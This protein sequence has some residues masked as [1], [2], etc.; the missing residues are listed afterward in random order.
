MASTRRPSALPLAGLL[1]LI[2]LVSAGQLFDRVFIIV[3][4]NQVRA[5]LPPC[6]R[7]PPC[8]GPSRNC[9]SISNYS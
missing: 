4:E 8:L 6:P 7:P 3:F 5:P 2:T 9:L 1:L